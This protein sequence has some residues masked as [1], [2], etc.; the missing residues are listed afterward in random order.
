[1]A[2]SCKFHVLQ[3]RRVVPALSNIECERGNNVIYNAGHSE[4]RGIYVRATTRLVLTVGCLSTTSSISSSI[5]NIT[6]RKWT[7][8][9]P[10]PF[11]IFFRLSE[12][13]ANRKKCTRIWHSSNSVFFLHLIIAC[14]AFPLHLHV[15]QFSKR[16]DIFHAL[17]VGEIFPK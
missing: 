4:A 14:V 16:I 11:V 9:I 5:L 13:G 10:S 1:L 6:H 12:S 2:G 8:S 17:S 7:A 15:R 3:V